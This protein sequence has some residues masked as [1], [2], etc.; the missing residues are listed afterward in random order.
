MVTSNRAIQI[1]PDG[2]RW[3]K[4][5]CHWNKVDAIE[6]KAVANDEQHR[7]KPSSNKQRWIA[8]GQRRWQTWVD[9][10]SKQQTGVDGISKRWIEEYHAGDSQRSE[11]DHV[12]S[13]QRM[14]YDR[15]GHDQRTLCMD[16]SCMHWWIGK[17]GRWHQHRGTPCKWQL[18]CI[19]NRGRWWTTSTQRNTMQELIDSRRKTMQVGSRRKLYAKQTGAQSEDVVHRWWLLFAGGQGKMA[20]DISMEEHRVSSGQQLKKDHVG[21][22]RRKPYG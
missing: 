3:S 8:H 2:C 13:G 4:S 14:L 22:S 16:G 19:A 1:G 15:Q 7:M 6:A 21:G 5:R 9:S 20:D 11:K 12:G 17:D 10:I 18:L